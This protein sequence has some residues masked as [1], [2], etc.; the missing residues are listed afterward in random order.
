MQKQKFN[1]KK[2]LKFVLK[3]K[4]ITI[5]AS[6]LFAFFLAVM[7]VPARLISKNGPYSYALY[8]RNNLL[9]GAQVAADQQWRFEPGPVPENFKKAIITYEDKRYYRH[10]GVDLLSIGRAIKLNTQ[11]KRI[12]SGGS[13]IT[14]QTVRILEKNPKRT[15]AQKIHEA[16]VAVLMEFRYSKKKILELYTANAPF[17]GNVVGLEAASWRYFNRAPSDLTWAEAATLAVLPNQP[18]LVYPGANSQI[19]LE[20][21]NQLLAK[22]Y[23]NKYFDQTTYELSLSEKLPGKPYPL[24][25]ECYHYLQYL[26]HNGNKNQTK[27]YT[28]IDSS[29]QRNCNRVLEQWSYKFSRMGINN[30]AA[31]ILDTETLEVL[32]YIG[33]TGFSDARNNT[34]GAVDIIQSKRSSG[35]LLK[36]FLYSAMLDSGQL[37][38]QQLVI[39]VPTRIGS[40][41]PDNNVPKYAGVVPADEALS[42]SLNIPA[43]R[44]LRDYGISAFMDY[45]KKCGFTTFN[46]S[47]DDYGLPLILGGGE[48]T[49]WEA[50][51]AYANMMNKV[52]NPKVNFPATSG[53]AY[54]TLTALSEGT[55]PDEEANWQR[56]ANSKRIAWKTG[57][58]SG[59]RDAWAIGVT[60]KYTVGVWIGNAEGVGTPDLKSVST[61]APVMFDIFTS[62]PANS[63]PPSPQFDL[64]RIE[65]CAHSGYASNKYCTET[66]SILIPR[67]TPIKTVCPYCRAYSFS[68]DGKYQASMDDMINE[69]EGQLP[70]IKNCFV[71]PPNLEYWYKR[72]NIGYMPLPEFVPW[73]SNTN[74]DNISIVFPEEG[75]NLVIPIEIDGEMGSMV[76]QAAVRSSDSVIYWDVDGEFLGT[77]EHKHEM[78]VS[79]KPGHHVLTIT[80]S[81]GTSKRRAFDVVNDAE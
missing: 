52:S 2:I 6:V 47:S 39:D 19:L 58:S 8:D 55:R 7:I 38:P 1:L 79:P 60:G 31:I 11:Q 29:M 13:T 54:I 16:W 18:S 22:M 37:M 68:P 42:R 28:T 59:N 23:E 71:L 65:V 41:R 72:T 21:R 73:H 12:V 78:K 35:S 36:P 53:S 51:R 4:V 15:Y 69:Y 26:K 40:Y 76:M 45:L 33:N 5:F 20:K 34:T 81:N 27:F 63:W 24:P 14:M 44:E 9:I 75:A 74:K 43:I 30:A 50:S 77:T 80:D 70:L 66:K 67:H 57:T 46:R 48:I 32:A 25:S 64:Q 17:G 62:L 3:H 56:Y 49:L 61:S 10:L